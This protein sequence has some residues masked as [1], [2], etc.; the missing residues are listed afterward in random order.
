[1][2]GERGAD[3]VEV[4]VG[5]DDRVGGLRARDAGAGGQAEGR[6]AR[7]R[8]REQRVDVAVIAARELDD[9]GAPRDPARE[10]D[11]AH[12][13]LGAG[14]D[15]AHLLDGRHPRDDLLGQLDLAGRRRAEREPPPGR[16]PHG[17]DDRRVRVPEDH[18]APGA[19][20]VDVAVAVGVGQPR[21]GR[22]HHE[23]RGA[24]DRLE[25]AD[26]R[27]HP[28]RDDGAGARKQLSRDGVH[29]PSLAKLS[30]APRTRRSHPG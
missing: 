22:R 26:R 21:S 19:D 23:P 20:E 8:R 30:D 24:A 12:G 6:D 27:V 15:Q 7:A 9:A 5:Q 3:G 4:V 17:L 1:M 13:G 29:A 28:T 16:V 25:G 10:P 18:R 11:R 2:L 14:V